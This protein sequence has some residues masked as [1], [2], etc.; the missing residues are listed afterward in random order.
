VKGDK[1]DT[2]DAG[3]QGIKGDKGDKGEKGEI[4]DAGAS[5]TCVSVGE[6]LLTFHLSDESAFSFSTAALV[7]ASITDYFYN[8]PSVISSAVATSISSNPLPTPS[9][10]QFASN[11]IA[12]AVLPVGAMYYD[13]SGV[14]KVVLAVPTALIQF[15][16]ANLLV[17]GNPSL[18]TS[19]TGNIYVFNT[20]QNLW[21]TWGL[22]NALLTS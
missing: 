14:V 2:G 10:Q 1:G 16:E 3:S 9:L 13:E 12:A 20:S 6:G 8:N 4:G 11:E 22:S 19:L 17:S 18:T 15:T 5:T 21:G 7:G